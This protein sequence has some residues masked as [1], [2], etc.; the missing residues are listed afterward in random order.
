MCG[1]FGAL[2]S[3]PGFNRRDYETFVRLTNVVRYRGPDDYGF[4]TFNVR[5]GQVDSRDSF[6]VFLGHRR[7]SVIDLSSS[8]R[9]PMP[10][11]NGCWIIFNGEIFNFVELRGELQAKG[12]HFQ[13]H[14]DTEVILHVYQEYGEAGFSKLNG[15]WAFALVDTANRRVVLSRDRFSIKPLY[16]LQLPNRVFFASEIKQ[17]LP[18]LPKRE[19]NVPVMTAFLAQGLIDHSP[20]TFFKSIS[21]I[22]SKANVIVDLRDFSLRK[23]TYWLYTICEHHKQ[24]TVAEQLRELLK[25][26]VRLRLRSD[27]KVGLLLSGGLDSSSIA[28]LADDMCGGRLETYSIISEDHKYSEEPYIDSICSDNRLRSHKIVFRSQDVL[29]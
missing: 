14:T 15:M 1:I 25:S 26:S 5:T 20:E 24:D 22:P 12:H 13:T 7:L 27:V 4:A 9:Q 23:C 17:L 8:G 19:L 6:D 10:D 29:E 2:T 11:G 28:V 18:L 3:T 16:L 21:K